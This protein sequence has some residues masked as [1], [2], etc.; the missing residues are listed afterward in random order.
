MSTFRECLKQSRA[1]SYINNNY[2]IKNVTDEIIQ[3]VCDYY[4]VKNW[5]LVKDKLKELK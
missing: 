4:N 5:S 2:N 3:D 1:I